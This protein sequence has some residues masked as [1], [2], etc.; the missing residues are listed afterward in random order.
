MAKSIAQLLIEIGADTAAFRTEMEAVKRINRETDDVV[1]TAWATV[2]DVA[3]LAGIGLGV[4]EL[5]DQFNQVIESAHQLELQS[6]KL[7]VGVEQYQKL[8]LAFKEGG[9]DAGELQGLI[10]KLSQEISAA[11]AG[12][13]GAVENVK[14][15]GIKWQ[16]LA[17]GKGR[18][19][20]DVL[21]E[22]AD[23]FSVA[24]DGANKNAWAIQML[25]R[26]GLDA[27]P[28]LNKG[29]AAIK[30]Y[31]EYADKLGAILGKDMVDRM[32]AVR[33]QQELLNA[34]WAA[35]KARLV[36]DTIPAIQQFTRELIIALN[37]YGSSR[38]A[39]MQSGANI[40]EGAW[41]TLTG[42]DTSAPADVVKQIQDRIDQ[43]SAQAAR[44]AA[45]SRGGLHE[46]QG[47]G[48]AIR[49]KDL[50]DELRYWQAMAE[51][52]K[53]I[54]EARTVKATAGIGSLGMWDPRAPKT[55][56][57]WGS[58]DLPGIKSGD[59]R[60][61]KTDL[62]RLIESLQKEYTV[63]SQG[64]EEWQQQALAVA[65]SNDKDKDKYATAQRL[66]EQLAKWNEMTQY[67]TDL[68]E[69]DALAEQ[70]LERTRQQFIKVQE[71]SLKNAQ[72]EIRLRAQTIVGYQEQRAIE[73][74]LLELQM[75]EELEKI[76]SALKDN[77]EAVAGLRRAR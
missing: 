15:R 55:D 31:G 18:P 46:G 53:A 25:G 59:L 13:R 12:N 49:I 40:M 14:D 45:A 39:L 24:S 52:D 43:V 8:A 44:E 7:G 34:S 38:K 26:A 72:E 69:G 64:T 2:S 51:S 20:V 3:Q 27:I 68:A 61:R 70:E 66:I 75:K 41:E 30:E 9:V 22:L 77:A 29:S 4:R 62:D 65:A 33:E 37:T 36:D 76:T 56:V 28:T 74:Q 47:G 57:P 6:Q 16:D 73:R 35:T 21:L 58:G 1:K 32:A 54:V 50:M 48:Y 23:R 19:V 11:E 42:R 67:A 63:A 71:Y 10:R 17:T 60:E 5:V